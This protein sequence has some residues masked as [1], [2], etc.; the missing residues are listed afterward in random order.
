MIKNRLF[1][2]TFFSA[3]V[4]RIL[5]IVAAINRSRSALSFGYLRFFNS[6]SIK[7]ENFNLIF[8]EK[9]RNVP[10]GLFL[11]SLYLNCAS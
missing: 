6:V 11:S 9:L 10:G 7:F 1:S 3:A 5:E 4:G 8:D 2:R